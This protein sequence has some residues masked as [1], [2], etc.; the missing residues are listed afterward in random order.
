[1]DYKVSVEKLVLHKHGKNS[2]SE[3]GFKDQRE[4]HML[5]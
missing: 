4:F 2:L 5:R 3:R 1:M